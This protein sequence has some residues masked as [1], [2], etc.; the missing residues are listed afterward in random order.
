L[1]ISAGDKNELKEETVKLALKKAMGANY[2]RQ[3][4][5]Y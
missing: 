3:S 1:E 2:D 5:S 4:S